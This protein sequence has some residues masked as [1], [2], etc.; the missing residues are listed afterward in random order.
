MEFARNRLPLVGGRLDAGGCF[1]IRRR[2]RSHSD[3]CNRIAACDTGPKKR[4]VEEINVTT[5]MGARQR[6]NRR[7]RK[8]VNAEEAGQILGKPRRTI[9]RWTKEGKMPPKANVWS[10]RIRLYRRADIVEMAR[11]RATHDRP[12]NKD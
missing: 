2:P 12:A 9:C 8:M 1:S 7:F 10:D 6:A 5:D 11:N 4:V 3:P